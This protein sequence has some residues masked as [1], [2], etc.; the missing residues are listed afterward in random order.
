[1]NYR[2]YSVLKSRS[3]VMKASLTKLIKLVLIKQNGRMTFWL[4][5]GL[6]VRGMS[7]MPICQRGKVF[8][9]LLGYI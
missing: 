2:Q 7:G 1:M 8:A 3:M 5:S 9:V 4:A 6:V